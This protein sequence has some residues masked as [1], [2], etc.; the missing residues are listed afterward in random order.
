M[1]NSTF[2]Q[3]LGL[4]MPARLAPWLTGPSPAISL[5]HMALEASFNFLPVTYAC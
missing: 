2:A 4:H 3:R 1:Q 5:A